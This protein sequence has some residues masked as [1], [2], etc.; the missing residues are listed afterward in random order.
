[1]E[2]L[3]IEVKSAKVYKLLKTLEDLKLIKVLK[4]EKK[5]TVKLS[6]KYAGSLP[7]AVVDNLHDQ[8]AES[9]ASW[10]QRTI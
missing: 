5:A 4:K 9:R 2:T 1:M 7:D 10:D 6:E 3:Y 8:V